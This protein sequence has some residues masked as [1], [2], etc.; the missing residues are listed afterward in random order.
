MVGKCSGKEVSVKAIV[1]GYKVGDVVLV[2]RGPD[3]K[4]QKM[5]IRQL[6]IVGFYVKGLA[7]CYYWTEKKITWDDCAA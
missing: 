2:L 4:P 3:G 5:E 1:N 6:G 7:T